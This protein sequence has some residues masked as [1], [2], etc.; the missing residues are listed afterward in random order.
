MQFDKLATAFQRTKGA[1]STVKVAGRKGAPLVA[2]TAGMLK[3]KN[4]V[5]RE[6]SLSAKLRLKGDTKKGK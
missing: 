5:K 1:D 4:K 6:K 3:R 2:E